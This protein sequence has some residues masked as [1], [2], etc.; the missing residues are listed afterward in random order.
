MNSIKLKIEILVF[1]Y[2]FRQNFN[3]LFLGSDQLSLIT[4]VVPEI[5]ITAY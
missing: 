5:S 4:I 2:Q 1:E 3:L